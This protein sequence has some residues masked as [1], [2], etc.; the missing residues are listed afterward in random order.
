MRSRTS[1]VS[2]TGDSSHFFSCPIFF[3]NKQFVGPRE[4]HWKPAHNEQLGAVKNGFT[5]GFDLLRLQGYL[6][7]YK[8]NT[9]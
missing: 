2:A 1:L 6:V 9:T 7:N 4:T 8:W 3:H 5:F